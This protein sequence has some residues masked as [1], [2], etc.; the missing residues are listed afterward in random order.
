VLS[1][2]VH[3]KV[4]AG[5]G[6]GET[7]HTV[8]VVRNRGKTTGVCK[9]PDLNEAQQQITL[10][11]AMDAAAHACRAAKRWGKVRSCSDSWRFFVVVIA[12][13]QPV[14]GCPRLTGH[15]VRMVDR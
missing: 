7:T 4:A 13:S 3:R 10:G 9:R 11:A 15:A 14:S 1:R 8:N 12:L 6:L 5:S 2:G